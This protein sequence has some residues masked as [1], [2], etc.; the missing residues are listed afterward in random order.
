[1]KD[2][3]AIILAAGEGKRMRSRHPKALHRIMGEPMLKYLLDI[4]DSLKIK[5]VFVLIGYKQREVKEYLDKQAKTVLQSPPLGTADALKKMRKVLA[6]FKGDFLVLYADTP[7]LTKRTVTKILLRH[8]STHASATILTC[9]LENPESYGKVIRDEHLKIARIIE[10]KDAKGKERKIREINV[11]VYCFKAEDLFKALSK[12]KSI[13]RK[14]E[15]YLTDTIGILRSMG[16]KIESVATPDIEEIQGINS[17]YDLAKAEGI[18]RRRILDKH[19]SKGV[20]IVDPKTTYIAG[21]VKIGQDTIV[22]PHSVIEREVR[23]GRDCRVGPFCRI[24]SGTVLGDR[25]EIGNFVE[26]VRSKVA[27]GSK[28]KHH[29]YIGD[30]I[31]GK[32]VNIGAGT[33]TANF[34]GHAKFV[35]KIFDGA[36]IGSGTVLVA[37][38]TVGR[39]AITGAGCVVTKG[40][41]VP[42]GAVVVGVPARILK[43]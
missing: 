6:N 19:I 42:A 12:V 7:L 25:V 5:D 27:G 24:R 39:A 33:I 4:A 3:V 28:I 20:T 36:F 18:I 22:Y 35:T 16:K 9:H 10:A 32:S 17:R 13:N 1:M 30:A 14:R 41:N 23:I 31:I 38:I 8:K 40:K 21:R 43:R 2:L 26:V 15:Y 11:G 34:D 37:P 29:S